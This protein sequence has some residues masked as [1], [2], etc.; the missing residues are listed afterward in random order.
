MGK[1]TDRK[2]RTA[3]PGKYGD[4]HGLRLIVRDDGTRSWVFR[5]MLNGRSR[6][7]G[8][9][10]LHTISLARARELATNYR[11][12]LLEGIDPIDERRRVRATTFDRKT[13][14]YCAEKYIDVM[15]KGWGN[16]K[17][18]KQWSSTLKTYAYPVLGDLPVDTIG[19]A[20]VLRVLEPIWHEKTVTAN[21]LRNRIESILDWAKVKE[22]RKGDNPARWRGHL[23]G[24]LP[25]P[26]EIVT[27]KHLPALPFAEIPAFMMALRKEGATSARALEFAI[28]TAARS[29]E[30]RGMK[31]NELDGLTWIVPA[32][33]M[34]GKKNKKREHRVPLPERALAILKEMK[35]HG[36]TGLVFK[37]P[38]KA[39]KPLNETTLLDVLRRMSRSDLTVHG[40]RSTFRDWVS[41]RTAFPGDVAE[42]ALAHTIRNKVQGAY[43]RGD[44]FEKRGKLMDAWADYCESPPEIEADVVPIRKG[45]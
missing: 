1:L 5:F 8:L 18:E 4:G 6:E 16:A 12:Q 42:A 36:E 39:G 40:F 28:L 33:R 13:F 7:M 29:G 9:G 26:D 44:L 37:S 30:V 22:Y 2:A 15:K 34:K 32:E 31:W 24:A 41:E 19:T 3:K 27:V 20:E 23:V 21:R 45:A 38:I 14:R 43:Q 11:G 35:K 17:H 25:K 10:P